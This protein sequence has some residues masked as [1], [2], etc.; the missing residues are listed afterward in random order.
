MKR[1][2]LALALIAPLSACD[3]WFGSEKPPLPGKRIAVLVQDQNLAPDEAVKDQEIVLPAPTENANWPQAGGYPNH[4]MHHILIGDNIRQAWSTDVGAGSDSAE[5]IVAQPVAADGRIFVTDA[6]EVV[7]A[8]NA[9]TGAQLWKMDPTSKEEEDKGHTSGGLAY[10]NGILYVA[11]GYGEVV[12]LA[13]DSGKIVWRHSVGQP[14]RSAPT[15]SSGR[16]FVATAV[17][18]LYALDAENGDQLW[19]HSGIE[20]PTN[21]LGGASPAVEGNVVVVGY[22]SGEIFAL[23][24]ENGQELWSDSIAGQRR[25]G[26]VGLSAI[27]GRPIIDRGAV[28]AAS[29]GNITAA[30]NLRTGRRVWDREIGS[31][32]SPWIA[33]DYLFE[34]SLNA[35]LVAIGRADGKVY[36]VS[37]LP[38]FKDPKDKTGRIVWAGPVLVSDRLVVAGSNGEAWSLSPYTGKLLG[39]VKLPDGVSIAPIVA[40]NTL[41]FLS[42]DA[43]LVAY[44]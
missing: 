30:I 11:M 33:G 8:L 17:N 18:K 13:A 25:T 27:R 22:S 4:A 34:I 36:W 44:R 20:E 28:Y 26:A 7:R 39:K 10:D 40:G 32:E 1:L 2:L 41:Y 5:R 14:L 24:V 15:V 9:Q 3:T 38:Q 29:F 6:D 23:R 12:A 42:D 31:T 21:L 16:V 35:E 37:Q 19:T 43:D